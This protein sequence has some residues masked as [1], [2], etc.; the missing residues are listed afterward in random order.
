[1]TTERLALADAAARGGKLDRVGPQA[2]GGERK[3]VAGA[4][5]VFKEQI[6]HAFT[7]QQR[8][9]LHFAVTHTHK[10]SRSV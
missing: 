4:G 9:L 7:A 5:A 8:H 3:A 1:M 2:A 6:E 10:V